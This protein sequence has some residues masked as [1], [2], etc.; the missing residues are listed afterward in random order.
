[1]ARILGLDGHSTIAV[2]KR[3]LCHRVTARKRSY[4]RGIVGNGL[5]L[6]RVFFLVDVV[7]VVGST[8]IDTS[9]S[10]TANGVSF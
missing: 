10:T 6:L 7:F 2:E 3:H 8:S 1:M 9:S 4:K 5:V